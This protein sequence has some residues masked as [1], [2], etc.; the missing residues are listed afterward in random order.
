M[1][2]S[3]TVSNTERFW[4][5]D[6]FNKDKTYF[7]LVNYLGEDDDY[8]AV[9]DHPGFT[10]K[11]VHGDY[12]NGDLTFEDIN[13]G[14]EIKL[15][16]ACKETRESIRIFEEMIIDGEK[17]I[18]EHLW[19]DPNP[20]DFDPEFFV[21]GHAYEVKFDKY[22]EPRVCILKSKAMDHMRFSFYEPWNETSGTIIEKHMSEREYRDIIKIVGRKAFRSLMGDNW[23]C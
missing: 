13:T 17:C 11:F 15:S 20:S 4:V 22:T 1:F 23:S 3:I 10:C 2:K 16:L 14:I 8:D 6:A 9:M 21:V 5:T 19:C 12:Q 18:Y 7:L